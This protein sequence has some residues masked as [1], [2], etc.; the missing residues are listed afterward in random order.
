ME[1]DDVWGERT[2]KN[3]PGISFS[4]DLFLRLRNK[5]NKQF[6]DTNYPEAL[7]FYLGEKGEIRCLSLAQLT[8]GG[9]T[10]WTSHGRTASS[11]SVADIL[12]GS[13][14]LPAPPALDLGRTVDTG[15]TPTSMKLLDHKAWTV[16]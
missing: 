15:R 2:N 1:A 16:V 8:V 11:P 12:V 4:R 7:L 6:C 3:K 5:S 13:A 14:E 10:L 9:G